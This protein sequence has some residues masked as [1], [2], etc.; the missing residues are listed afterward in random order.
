[1]GVHLEV[2]DRGSGRRPVAVVK[3]QQAPG[4]NEFSKEIQIDEDV[5]EYVTAV[6][7]SSISHKAFGHQPREHNLG[8]VCQQ[9]ADVTE[10]RGDDPIPASV[11]ELVLVGRR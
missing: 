5:V 3:N 2:V 6:Y 9:G 8:S 11:P 1:M 7:E 4:T 10:T